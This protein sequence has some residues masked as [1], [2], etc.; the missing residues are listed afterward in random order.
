MRV[1]P[2]T[3][4]RAAKEMHVEIGKNAQ[5]AAQKQAQ[6]ESQAKSAVQKPGSAQ[7]QNSAQETV[8][9]L[10]VHAHQDK[11]TKVDESKSNL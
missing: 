4:K 2:D 10:R 9:G 1:R 7:E 5:H 3:P 8:A 11:W 6:Q